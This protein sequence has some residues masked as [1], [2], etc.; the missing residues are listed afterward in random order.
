MA[1]ERRADVLLIGGGVA[2]VR[3][4]RRLRRG[5]FGGSIL[6]VGDEPMP[7]YNRPPLSKEVLSGHVSPDLLLA[8]PESWYARREVTLLTGVAVTELDVAGRRARLDDGGTVAFDACLIATGAEPM[9]PAL[10]GGE[11][12]RL[13]R[14]AADATALREEASRLAGESGTAAV[15]GGGFIGVEVAAA[16]AGLGLRV[17]LVERSARL[18][19][20]ALGETISDWARGRL[21]ALGVDVHLSTTATAVTDEALLA[22]GERFAAQ[23]VVGGVGVEPRVALAEAAGLPVNDGVVVDAQRRSAPR[24]HAAGDVARVPHPLA[25]GAGIR[26]EHWHAAREGGEAAALAI[27]GEP[28]PA[29]RAPWVYSEFGG[30][31]LD[32]VGWA[33][34]IEDE[35][36]LG[37][38]ADG[39]FAV[40]HMASGRVAQLAIVNGFLPVDEARR[41]V[42]RSPSVSELASFGSRAPGP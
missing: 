33:P 30:E 5:G 10:P 41:F 2:A 12:L 22:A 20:G 27:L 34:A 38:R 4:A 32:V 6:L 15:L 35:V 40:A 25:G 24:I 9:R 31:L 17:T 8:E 3:C 1:E 42:E 29:P 39:R 21:A 7:P 28:V 16:L 37:D 36:L 26:V 23:L 19:A 14:T 13:L 18:W 11:R